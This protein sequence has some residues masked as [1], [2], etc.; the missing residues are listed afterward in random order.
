MKFILELK[1]CGY[2]TAISSYYG[3]KI[4]KYEQNEN[5]LWLP[6]KPHQPKESNPHLEHYLEGVADQI[7]RDN[8]DNEPFL[9]IISLM[10]RQINSLSRKLRELEHPEEIGGRMPERKSNGAVGYDAYLRAVVHHAKKD[11]EN[12][13]LRKTLFDFKSYPKDHAIRRHVHEVNGELVYRMDPD[14]SVLVGIGFGTDMEIFYWVCPRSGLATKYNITVTNA[15]GT[16][17]PDY[18][19]EAGVIVYNRNKETYDLKHNMRIAQIL[20]Q[21]ALFPKLI[22][23]EKW[24]DLSDTKDSS[25][26]FGHTGLFG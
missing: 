25:G 24:E 5:G 20:F 16:V 17:D 1:I 14:E 23:V 6:Y 22:K 13:I 19:G 9:R 4:N 15:P 21:K 11:P 10:A 8:K 18:R 12:P 3:E 2:T 26:G 7:W